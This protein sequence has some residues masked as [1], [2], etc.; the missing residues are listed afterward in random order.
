[1]D[2]MRR[3]YTFLSTVI[4]DA[5]VLT[6]D[7]LPNKMVHREG[8]R[9]E[10]A[11]CLRPLVDGGSPENMLLYGPPGT[12]KTA[13]ANYVVEE[14][15]EKVFANSSYVNCFSQKSRF[16]IFYELLDQKLT[17]PRDGTSTEKIID[18]FEEKTR[19]EPTV[20]IIDEVD[21]IT[22]DEVLYELSRFQNVGIIFIANDQKIFSHFEDRV[23]SRLS[24]MRRIHFRRY[25]EDELADIL[26]LRQEHGLKD[27]SISEGQ[28]KEIAARSGGDARMALNSLRFAAREAERQELE[29][30]TS[31]IV[32]EAVSDAYDENR[33]ESLS[34]LNEHQ[35]AA[36]K[37]LQEEGEMQIGSLYD[38][39]Q[40]AVEEDKSRRTLLRYLK[41]MVNYDILEMEGS[42]SS[43]SYRIAEQ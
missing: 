19:K 33:L 34:R 12:G 42:T 2:S 23:R 29:Q 15:K 41:K 36:Y 39:Y 11:R 27:S 5:R 4:E 8:E 9:Q 3:G 7:Y 37:I 1:M 13:M 32:E 24:G 40:E 22:D 6:A 31:E 35:K 30:I 10:I 17:T 25:N 16:E 21:Q 38:K 18:M 28:L 20:V 43:A 26:E 14:L